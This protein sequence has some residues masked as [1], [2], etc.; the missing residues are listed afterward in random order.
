[1]CLSYSPI[2]SPGPELVCKYCYMH[3]T[4]AFWIL[5]N[6]AAIRMLDSI[7]CCHCCV[8][9]VFILKVNSTQHEYNTAIETGYAHIHITV[10]L[11]HKGHARVK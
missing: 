11:Y 8:D 6:F 7:W 2:A 1:M 4:R 10:R 3:P 5:I 9:L